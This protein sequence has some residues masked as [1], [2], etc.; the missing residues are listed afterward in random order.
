MDHNISDSRVMKVP[1]THPYP[2]TTKFLVSRTIGKG[3]DHLEEERGFEN[4]KTG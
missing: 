3:T 1:S 4:I 2:G